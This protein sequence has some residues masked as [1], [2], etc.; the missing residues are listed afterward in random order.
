MRPKE[1]ADWGRPENLALR[2]AY[3]FLPK[4]IISRMTVRLHRFVCN[5]EM[6]WT[7]LLANGSEIELRGPNAK[8]FYA[9]LQRTSMP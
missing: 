7:E 9:P 2:Y 3:A 1:L 8:R 5:P 6:A 4:G